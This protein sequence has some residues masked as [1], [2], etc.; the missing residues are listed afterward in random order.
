M[1]SVTLVPVL[2]DDHCVDFVKNVKASHLRD[3]FLSFHKDCY[4]FMEKAF[5][6]DGKFSRLKEV[7]KQFIEIKENETYGWVLQ[8][9]L[10]SKIS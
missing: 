6:E 9:Y 1:G 2:K 8:L 7:A 5:V 10:N 4:E 3:H